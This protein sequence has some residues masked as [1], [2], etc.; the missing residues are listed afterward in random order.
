[1]LLLLLS[2]FSCVW[3]C[4]TPEMAAH[5][6]PSPLGFS[7]QEHWSGLPFP[8][9]MH[10]SEKWKWSRSVVSD[11]Q[12]PQGPQPT[13]L[14]CPWDFPGKSTGM[15][16]HCFLRKG[17]EF[18]QTLKDHEGQGRTCY[19]RKELDTTEQL[20]NNKVKI[21]SRSFPINSYLLKNLYQC[22]LV[23]LVLEL[24]INRSYTDFY[25]SYFYI[26]SQCFWDSSML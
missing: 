25:I 2:H 12:R 17:H 21:P 8:S 10:E 11:S 24:Y 9:P 7:R 4:A 3:L 20:N 16:C 6:A 14:L 15:G 1:M 18:E 5:Q 23:L 19:S 22:K 26:F 13:R